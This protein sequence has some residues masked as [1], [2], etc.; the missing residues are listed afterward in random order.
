MAKSCN[1]VFA[2]SVKVGPWG[3]HSGTPWSYKAK[4]AITEIIISSGEVVDSIS[5]ASVD[6]ENIKTYSKKFGGRGGKSKKISIGWPKE[7]LI[8]ISGSCGKYKEYIVI[9]SI[10]FHTNRSMYGPFGYYKK[11]TSFVFP[12][13][14]GVIDG[15]YGRAG[16]GEG[17]V[18]AIGIFVKPFEDLSCICSTQGQIITKVN[19]VL[20]VDVPREAGPWGG[21]SGK[22]FDD[23][24]FVA[25]KHVY[26]HVGD[27]LIHAIQF[28][29][30]TK[31]V[32]VNGCSEAV[33][34]ITFYSNK[35]KYG[36]FGLE[37]GKSFSSTLS[38]GKVVGFHGR[39]GVYF[40]AI[41]KGGHTGELLDPAYRRWLVVSQIWEEA[42][43]FLLHTKWRIG[44][45]E[46]PPFALE[47]ATRLLH[48]Q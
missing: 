44:G 11:G 24:V 48:L 41:G 27:G 3:G 20:N 26:V 6:T 14:L 28:L 12:S 32:D 33:R 1:H 30:Q 22:P 37:I 10:C 5:F 46:S 16:K 7:Y 40:D 36:P 19:E 25:I 17:Y 31:D 18:D 9:R 13:K 43:S 8:S 2:D 23:G 21:N 29:Y 42:A 39:S 34:S 15:F 45:C 35:G 4:G 47:G 38:N